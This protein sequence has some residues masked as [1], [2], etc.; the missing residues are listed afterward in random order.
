VVMC[1]TVQGKPRY[2]SLITVPLGPNASSARHGQSMIPLY[3]VRYYIR[4]QS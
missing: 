2:V 1:M 4:G 3:F